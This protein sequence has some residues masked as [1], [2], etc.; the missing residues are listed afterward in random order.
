MRPSPE[1]RPW[2]SGVDGGVLRR[3][4][5]GLLLILAAVASAAEPARISIIIDDMG[6]RRTQD[7]AAVRLPGPLAYAFLPH[8]PHAAELAETAFRGNKEVLLHLPMQPDSRRRP[9]PGA[10]TTAM[11]RVELVR[12]V[13]AGLSSVPFVS[14]IN[15]HMGSL[16]TAR[17]EHMGW[18][19]NLMRARGNLYFVDSRTTHRTV[20][21]EEAR[22]NGVPSTWRD[23]FLDH[24]PRASSIGREFDRLLSIARRKGTALAIGHPHPETIRFLAGMI[25][26]LEERNVRLVPVARLIQLRGA[27]P[28]PFPRRTARAAARPGSLAQSSAS[29]HAAITK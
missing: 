27:A 15:N 25:P 10:I 2:R 23:V 5:A 26:R 12:T 1:A 4:G 29:G 16:I 6:N 20:A 9:G 24:D 8:S 18:L 3:V 22:T 11:D 21:L 7:L 17:R 28:P 13:G 19:M 14:G